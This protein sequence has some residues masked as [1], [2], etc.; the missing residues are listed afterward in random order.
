MPK[1]DNLDNIIKALKDNNYIETIEFIGPADISEHNH[2][3]IS[4]LYDAGYPIGFASQSPETYTFRVYPLD[5]VP[6]QAF[7]RINGKRKK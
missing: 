1:L 4:E 2:K 7:Q 6:P 3:I 5:G